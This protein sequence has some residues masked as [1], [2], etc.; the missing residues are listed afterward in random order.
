LVCCG[1]SLVISNQG[2]VINGHGFVGYDSSSSSNNSVL[3]TG[4]GS[5]WSNQGGLYVGY[6]GVSNTL[7]IANGGSVIA[8]NA[9]VGFKRVNGNR[10]DVSGG[11]LCVT[12]TVGNGP[13]DLRR[14]T[15]TFNSG[16]ITVDNLLLT[17]GSA[18]VLVFNGGVLN[19]KG[20]AVTN[21]AEF[22]VGNGAASANFHLLGGVHSFNNGLRIRNNAILSGCGTISGTV[23][24]DAGGSVVADCGGTLTFTDSLTNNGIVRA[25]NGSVLEFYGPVV[26][27]GIIDLL[28]GTTNSHSTFINNGTIVG[29]SDFQIVSLT[30]E[31]SNMRISW[32]SIGGRSYAV[33]VTA[34]DSAGGYTNNFTD[35]SPT[36]V[37]PGASL[38]TTN[39]LDVG[40]ATNTPARFYR[41]RLVP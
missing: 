14:G 2:Q 28:D 4:S 13:L 34:G 39:Y 1:N 26:N 3:V 25:E 10:I 40:A 19:S 32:P 11:S 6:S 36:I 16:T 38:L 29:A 21:V 8:S 18:S 7:T 5:V 37:I 35:L 12:N 23:V 22:A 27:N 20:T 15:L 24:I 33:Q 17:N 9:Y 41:V 30:Q 31:G